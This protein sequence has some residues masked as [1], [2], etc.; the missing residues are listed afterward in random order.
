MENIEKFKRWLSNEE[1]SKES[2][3]YLIQENAP[4]NYPTSRYKDKRISITISTHNRPYLLIRLLDSILMQIYSNYEIVIVDDNSTDNTKEIV[5]KY[6][7]EHPASDIKYYANKINR[8]VSASKKRGFELCNGEIIIFSDDDDYYIDSL[9]FRKINTIYTENPDCVMTTASTLYH[10]EKDDTYSLAK[11]NFNVP[12]DNAEYL[13][14]FPSKYNKPGSMFTLSLN[15]NKMREIDY[16]ELKCFNDMSLYLYGALAEGRVFP[17]E[18]AVGVYS[19]QVFSMSSGVSASYTINNLEAKLDIGNKA[20][21][22]GYLSR[23]RQNEWNYKQCIPTLMNFFC[24]NIKGI[25]EIFIVNIWVLKN[26]RISCAVKIFCKEFK[27]RLRYYLCK[28][29]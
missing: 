1:I 19:V 7:L 13:N 21:S 4:K 9:Y 8:G 16:I 26:M 14:G 5:E 20:V 10:Y 11:L 28:I 6:I 24:G 25:N 27:A 23:E 22:Y 15:A 18:E 29:K 17:I 12:I 3:D 2:Y